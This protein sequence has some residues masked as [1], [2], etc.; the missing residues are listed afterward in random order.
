[1]L[2][3]FLFLCVSAIIVDIV[4]TPYFTIAVI[5]I[6]VVYYLVQHFFRFTSREL[7]RLDAI[8]KSPIFSL[9][10]QTIDGLTTIRAFNEEIT[11][12][13]K[14]YELLD[15]NNICFLMVNSANCWLGT[16]LFLI[17]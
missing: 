13:D 10:G 9:F 1:M 2:L 8:T 16:I 14:I 15:I 5:P 4:L 6:L 17:L 11:F 7:Q 12:T 3:R